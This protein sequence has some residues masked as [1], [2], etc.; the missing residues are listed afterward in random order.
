M[1]NQNETKP[2]RDRRI[3]RLMWIVFGSLMLAVLLFF[4]L[5]YNGIIGYMPPVE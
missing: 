5:I 4:I 1:D 3:I 2:D